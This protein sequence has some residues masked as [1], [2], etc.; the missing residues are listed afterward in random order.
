[1]VS[2]KIKSDESL[3]ILVAHEF[4]ISEQ[5]RVL[6]FLESLFDSNIHAEILFKLDT[7]VKAISIEMIEDFCKKLPYNYSINKKTN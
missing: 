6:L 1:M 4:N 5:D 3:T 7:N 2:F